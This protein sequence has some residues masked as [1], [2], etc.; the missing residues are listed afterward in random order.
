MPGIWEPSLGCAP[1]YGWVFLFQISRSS[2]IVPVVP[3][4]K[5]NGL[6]SLYHSIFP[7]PV[8]L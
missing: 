6:Q 2:I 7:G 5:Q 8:V 3:L 4:P 1:L